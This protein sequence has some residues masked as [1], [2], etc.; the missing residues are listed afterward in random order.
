MSGVNVEA[1]SGN[2]PSLQGTTR[3][4]FQRTDRVRAV[5]E[6]YQGTA[7]NEAIVPVSM[8]VQI[9][10]AKNVAVRDQTLP[11]A[12]ATFTNRRAQAVITLPLA[13]LPVGD[14]LFKLDASAG[15]TTTGRALRFGVE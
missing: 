4:V 7:R 12:E 6:I 14:Y 9:L 10:D 15:S 5:F 13:N 11:F 8:H 1:G 3:R 2:V